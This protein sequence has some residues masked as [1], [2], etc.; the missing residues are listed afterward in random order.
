M[1][2]LFSHRI[3]RVLWYSGTRLTKSLSPTGLSPS[4]AGFSKPFCS[5]AVVIM[6]A[7]Y[8]ATYRYASVW[9]LPRSL[10]TTRGIDCFLSL[11]P[12]NKM[13]QFPGFPSVR[14]V[15]TYGYQDILLVS[16]LIRI[17][18]D[19]CSFTAP[20]SFSQLVTSFFGVK[21][22]GIHPTLFVA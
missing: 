22:Q 9:A 12:G 10:A 21:C 1:V 11:P 8:P 19:Q 20:H 5:A 6:R 13:F 14:Y 4:L 15:F 16:F 3:P 7:L 18:V 2:L 17:S